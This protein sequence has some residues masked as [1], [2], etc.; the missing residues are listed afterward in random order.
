MFFSLPFWVSSIAISIIKVI[1]SGAVGAIFA[2]YARHSHDLYANSIRWSRVG[3]LLETLPL[4]WNSRR[5]VPKQSSIAMASM[6]LAG[7][8]NMV[9]AIFL[10]AAVFRAESIY[11]LDPTGAFTTQLVSADSSFRLE[12]TAFMEPNDTMK[13]TLILLL[14]DTRSHP[15]PIPQTL[16]EPRTY[17]YDYEITCNETAA[18]LAQDIH[19]FTF[20]YPSPS[21]ACKTT[22]AVLPD[23]SFNLNLESAS[24]MLVS[25]DVYMVVAAVS[26]TDDILHSPVPHVSGYI[27]KFCKRTST[28]FSPVF[29]TFPK[30]GIA[31]LPW[32]DLTRCQYG[33]GE[34][35]VMAST[36]LMFAINQLKDFDRITTSIFNETA[37]LPLLTPMRTAIN[38][39][40]F[41]NPTNNA[42]MVMFTGLSPNVDFFVCMSTFSNRTNGMGLLC[43]YVLTSLMPLK[44]QPW[45]PYMPEEIK[46]DP[47]P[48][49]DNDI[50]IS[51]LNLNIQH[52]PS[53]SQDSMLKFSP[54][55]LLESTT[56]ATKYIASLGYNVVTNKETGQL[57]ILYETRKVTD[58]FEVSTALLIFLAVVVVACL[59]I[60]ITSEVRYSTVYNG[61]LYKVIYQEIFVDFQ[62]DMLAFED[63]QES[64]LDVDEKPSRLSQEKSMTKLDNGSQ[65]QLPA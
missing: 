57:Y 58:A 34:S 25:P 55:H 15:A 36:Y 44:P 49:V 18:A 21:S 39:G 1:L 51:E 38:N 26:Y 29:T 13:E 4:L 48:S 31:A 20:F 27:R 35:I 6:I 56:D 53:G 61:S 17:D 47:S 28:L 43:T 16:Y 63:N 46:P 33:S 5:Q 37:S 54:A 30:D 42:T 12:W 64:P 14:S 62:D 50:P 8:F 7:L 32:T 40:T 2:I 59:A 45:D 19:N 10:G 65:D 11:Q 41:L 22:W 24:N 3:G 60:W 23:Y 52:M 9:V